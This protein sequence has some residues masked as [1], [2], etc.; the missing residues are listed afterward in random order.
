MPRKFW[1]DDE[2][3]FL[4]RIIYHIYS[5]GPAAGEILGIATAVGG[6]AL[7]Y[8]VTLG[9]LA[10]WGVSRFYLKP[11][12]D[13]ELRSIEERAK[14][15]EKLTSCG[16]MPFDDTFEKWETEGRYRDPEFDDPKR[17]STRS[18]TPR[19]IRA[20]IDSLPETHERE[21]KD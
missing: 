8:G 5:K 18:L 14:R 7:H 13:E 9:G 1:N 2:M 4:G 12:A 19:D 11:K 3:D 20:E 6:A 15:L 21:Y 10:A 17:K 16:R